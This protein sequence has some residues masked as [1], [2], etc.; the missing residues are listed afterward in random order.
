MP[1][2]ADRFLVPGGSH[3]ICMI[4]VRR[5]TGIGSVLCRSC[6]AQNGRVGSRWSSLWSIWSVC[7]T[8]EKLILRSILRKI[9]FSSSS[10]TISII[11]GTISNRRAWENKEKQKEKNPRGLHRH[12]RHAS[13]K[14]FEFCFF[15]LSH[16][17][18]SA[19]TLPRAL[20]L[21]SRRENRLIQ[22]TLS[23]AIEGTTINSISWSMWD[24]NQG[25]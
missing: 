5:V 1:G 14:V 7:P 21:E 13:L 16:E 3:K 17:L 12:F 2:R 19:A 10:V 18:P 20:Q 9:V 23:R 25:H 11:D 4:Y 24:I 8:C 6:T 22:T 15:F